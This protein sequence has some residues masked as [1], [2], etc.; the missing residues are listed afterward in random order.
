[1]VDDREVLDR[2][3]YGDIMSYSNSGRM[4]ILLICFCEARPFVCLE[5][6]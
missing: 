6:S 3:I 2:D 1:M 5:L 4:V